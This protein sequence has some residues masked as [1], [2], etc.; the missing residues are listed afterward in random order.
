MD[1]LI[2]T[3]VKGISDGRP[4][5]IRVLIIVLTEESLALFWHLGPGSTFQKRSV[6]SPA[7]ASSP[8]TLPSRLALSH[9]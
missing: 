4:H 3:I 1:C 8:L 6:S 7:S 5:R 2:T 9:S